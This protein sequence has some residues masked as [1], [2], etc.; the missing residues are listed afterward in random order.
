LKLSTRVRYG[1]RALLDLAL[2]PDTGP[3]LLKDIANRQN[4]SLQY[5]EHIIGPLVNSGIVKST[6]GV[7]GGI[8]LNQRPEDVK[9]GE[10]VRLLEGNTA[11]VD[12]IG[13]PESCNRSHQCVTR[14]VWCEMKRAIDET[15]NA[16]TLRDLVERRNKKTDA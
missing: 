4:I 5:L 14:D 9:L 11:P 12:C 3:V 7:N 2:Q 6:R 15:L 8:Q 16:V 13:D 10:V 1:T